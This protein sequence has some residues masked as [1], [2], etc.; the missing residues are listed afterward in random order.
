MAE[1]EAMSAFGKYTYV[2]KAALFVF[3][4]TML[5]LAVLAWPSCVVGLRP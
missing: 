2:V 5:A 1:E 3:F 4:C